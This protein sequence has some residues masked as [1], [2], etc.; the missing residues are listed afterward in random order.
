MTPPLGLS[1]PEVAARVAAGQTNAAAAP[2]SRSLWQIART[3]LFT[4]F[5]NIL[6]AIG[7][8]LIALGRWND[9]ATSVGLG[10]VNALIGTAQ[11]IRSKRKLDAIQ[12][13]SE[14]PAVVMRDGR[15]QEISPAHVV[16]DEIV[17]LSLESRSSSTAS[18]SLARSAS[19]SP[20]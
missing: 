11:E 17:R 18:W 6:F 1:S 5:N 14:R 7:V 4:F 16:L 15:E 9:A 10:L 2:P 8:A 13:L 19:T 20:C 3:N 12:L